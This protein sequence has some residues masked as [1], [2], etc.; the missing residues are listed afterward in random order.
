MGCLHI[1]WLK[2]SHSFSLPWYPGTKKSDVDPLKLEHRI[3]EIPSLY[4]VTDVRVCATFWNEIVHALPVVD[5]WL[6]GRA[7]NNMEIAPD[8]KQPYLQVSHGLHCLIRML[9][10]DFYLQSNLLV[11]SMSTLHTLHI[12]LGVFNSTMTT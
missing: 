11:P 8:V 5:S 3:L 9:G 2:A 7:F 10:I 12:F 4:A 1:H 6:N